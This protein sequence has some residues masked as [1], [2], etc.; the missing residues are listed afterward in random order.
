MSKTT[1]VPLA[2]LTRDLRL[3]PRAEIND[4][5][6]QEYGDDMRN[7]DVFPPI[8]VIGEWLVDGWHRV[9]AAE[10]I[11]RTELAAV[12]TP[13]TFDEAED[14][15]FTV[16]RGHGLRRTHA[17]IQAA[18]RR[19]LLTNRWVKRADKWISRVVGCSQHTV[20]ATRERLEA[21]AQIAPLDRLL[22]EDGKWYPRTRKDATTYTLAQWAELTTA[23]QARILT[24]GTQ[25][26]DAGGFNKQDTDSI[27]WARWSWNPVTG[28]KH[29]CP[30]CYA[31]DI[32]TRYSGTAAYPVGFEP[33]LHPKRL[34]GPQQVQVPAAAETDLGYRNVF[35]CS[36]AD[37]FGRWVPDAWIRA[38]LQAVTDAPQWNFL[39]LTKFPIRLSSFV[40]PKNAWIGTS[41]DC[42]ARVR[43]AE[44]AFANV[45]AQVK[46]LSCE[47]LIEPL[48]FQ[49]LS[50][51]D[52]VVIGGASA[53]TQPPATPAWQPPRAWVD[54][55]SRAAWTAG[56]R[57]Y[58][59]DNLLRRWRQYPG[60]A[61][62]P[63]QRAPEPFHY[64]TQ[65]A[66]DDERLEQR[67]ELT[68]SS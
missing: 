36:M 8:R 62:E 48:H 9:A 23:A 37:L 4:A 26:K 14:F 43:N 38:V 57:V 16:N 22:G 28:C 11:G 7:G 53:S 49:D 60:H 31:R 21:G 15:T 40:F 56:C 25:A 33:V 10:Q 65:S 20:T 68:L 64:L 51:F 27:E 66:S 3:Q 24:N 5:I 58:E 6:V 32:A 34:A 63:L 59:K 45:K 30:Y 17:D 41:V 61:D 12:V 47:P 39:F 54:D 35:V 52:W 29:N 50:V 67:V 44:T 55:L 18:I 46:W 42:Q 13:G 2:R 19:A 1:M